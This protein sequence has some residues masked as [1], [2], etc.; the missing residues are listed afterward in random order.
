MGKGGEP[1][2]DA[3]IPDLSAM[4]CDVQCK[5]AAR[6][7]CMRELEKLKVRDFTDVRIIREGLRCK[8]RGRCL[9]QRC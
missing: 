5:A 9:S 4:V 6:N 2:D 7:Y 8:G 1:L 3:G